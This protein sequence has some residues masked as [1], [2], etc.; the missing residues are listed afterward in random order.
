MILMSG[1]RSAGPELPGLF[2]AS[3]CLLSVLLLCLCATVFAHPGV[4]DQIHLLSEDIRSAPQDQYL[5]IQRGLAYSN[6]NEPALALADIAVAETLGNPVDVAFAHGILLYRAGDFIGA[7]AYF[8]RYLEAY[9]QHLATLEYRARLLRDAGEYEA[10]LDDF[11]QLFVLNAMPDPGHYVSAAKMMVALPEHGISG[12]LAL[13]DGRMAQVGV[14]S[15]LQRYAIELEQERKNYEG[16]IARQAALAPALRAS[17]QWQL[18]MAQLQI[19]A[20]HTVQ[21][22]KYLNTATAQLSTLRP[23]VARLELQQEI[24]ALLLML[25]SDEQLMAPCVN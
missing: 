19:G 18:E 7:R 6:N 21:A 10:A 25:D 17:P 5:H 3:Q 20:G 4:A 8:D 2:P 22:R 24:E 9:P 13:L 12:A 23:T 11:Q 14:T 1:K 16:A 15:Q